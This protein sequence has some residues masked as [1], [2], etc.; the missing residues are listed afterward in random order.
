MA[1]SATSSGLIKSGGIAKLNLTTKILPAALMFAVLA[2]LVIAVT[3]SGQPV[4]AQDP[5]PTPTPEAKGPEGKGKDIPDGSKEASESQG[6]GVV[7]YAC[8]ITPLGTV[9]GTATR[10][11]SWSSDCE[12]VNRSDRYARFYSFTVSETSDV[13][14]DL[15][16]SVDTYM[17]LLSGSGTSGS[18]LTY[19]DDG[20]VG[21]DSQIQIELSAGT[22][23]VEATTYSSS[24][25]GSFTL[26][27]EA[28]STSPPTPV[29]TVTSLGT[30]SGTVTRI[31]SW[32][33]D[34]ESVNRSDK[35]A[36]FYSFSVGETS[37][38]QIDLSASE[39]TYM[40]LLSGSGTTG[41]VLASDDDGGVGR[42]SQIQ[43]ELSAGTYTVEA[44][45]FSSRRTG[46]FTLTIQAASTSTP[47]TPT[48]TPTPSCTV[49]SLGTISSSVTRIGSWASDCESANRSGRYARFYSISVA[50]TSD[51]QIDLS[52]SVDTY[53]YL[54]SG[55]GTTGPVLHYDDD[56]GDD[57]N[58]RIEATLSA[59]TYT[60]EATTYASGLTGSFTLTIGVTSD[61]P[62]IEIQELVTTMQQGQSDSFRVW[63]SNLDPSYIY[64]A[65]ITTSN[66]DLAFTAACASTSRTETLPSSSISASIAFT[67]HG[68]NAPG[69]RVT[70]TL[71]RGS[72]FV[73]SDY[74]DVEVTAAPLPSLTSPTAQVELAGDSVSVAYNL[75]SPAQ[76]D[77]T[78]FDY[79]LRLKWGMNALDNT[80]NLTNSRTEDLTSALGV[81]R[82]TGLAPDIDG[83]YRVDVE[84]CRTGS[85]TDCISY[86]DVGFYISTARSNVG[87][88]GIT[89]VLAPTTD[90]RV[91]FQIDIAAD[92]GR[93]HLVKVDADTSPAGVLPKTYQP[94][95][96]TQIG[97]APAGLQNL[98]DGQ[99]VWVEAST[100][101]RGVTLDVQS[102]HST[103]QGYKVSISK[104]DFAFVGRQ[105]ERMPAAGATRGTI[106][107][108][109][110][111]RNSSQIGSADEN[112]P[113]MNR[114]DRVAVYCQ[115]P[116]LSGT[117]VR[118]HSFQL[119][120]QG[121]VNFLGPGSE[122][123]LNLGTL[124]E[125][126]ALNPSP[127]APGQSAD[128]IASVT[129][130]LFVDG[131]L[132]HEVSTTPSSTEW[133]FNVSDTMWHR[134]SDVMGGLQLY[135][136]APAKTS[137]CT[138]SFSVELK[139]NSAA[140]IRHH[141]S[142]NDI[143]AV[144]TTG[145][146]HSVGVSWMQGSNTT[147]GGEFEPLGSTLVES[148]TTTC[149]F[150]VDVDSDAIH[151]ELEN[152]NC[153][154]GDQTYSEVP[155]PLA[156]GFPNNVIF[157]PHTESPSTIDA[158]IKPRIEYFA[159][160]NT[161]VSPNPTVVRFQIVGARPPRLG[162]SVHKA[163]R[164][165]GWTSGSISRYGVNEDATCPGNPVG[166]TDNQADG[167]HLECL[168]FAEYTSRGG[169]SGSPVFVLADKHST[170]DVEV[171]LVGV[172]YGGNDV[173]GT[174][175]FV[176][177]DRVYAESLLKGYDWS[178]DTQV[179][180][181]VP[182]LDRPD[183]NEM[184]SVL[185]DGPTIRAA[186][187]MTDFSPG[188]GLKYQAG[189]FRSTVAGT[190]T[191]VRIG[192]DD[193]MQTVTR[194]DPIVEFDLSD[195]GV[196]QRSGEF[197]VKA[198]F[199]AYDLAAKPQTIHCGDY[200]TDGGKAVT[201]VPAPSV[202]TLSRLANGDVRVSW[203]AVATTNEYKLSYRLSSTD[204]PWL[205]LGGDV[206][207][208][209][210]ADVSNLQCGSNKS[211]EFRVRAHADTNDPS[212][213]YDGTWGFW[214]GA[215]SPILVQCTGARRSVEAKPYATEVTAV[216]GS[217]P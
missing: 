18:V 160:D 29:C 186:F 51:V 133:P 89:T 109:V 149:K 65:E 80:A 64:T 190:P 175:A 179:V 116:G 9:S 208:T 53:V 73:D 40:F 215:S 7:P 10:S 85:M 153:H 200:G 183:P 95:E 173:T 201:P 124:C 136:V 45:T 74:Q 20:G 28:S 38:V 6:S 16:S 97:T 13:Q 101:T 76:P 138:S 48:P 105:V 103:F 25:T 159:V 176:P 169:D 204:D 178:T 197:S 87:N 172:H 140:T 35:Y 196:D 78:E 154:R 8:T 139:P 17:F 188:L 171:I 19:D 113:S 148:P 120:R 127:P 12:S 121:R 90:R 212:N 91:E 39:D 47:P 134:Q 207:T 193:A 119:L 164:T 156:V 150:M 157:K 26:T 214:S 145:H 187:D 2:I 108:T 77:F 205:E 42:D 54:L 31:G 81:H 135:M 98:G 5:P 104:P 99:V 211:Y 52:S 71:R 46:S 112:D 128:Q 118:S 59:G 57:R 72:T 33:N 137:L 125:G 192:T 155:T 213:P 210:A 182:T 162:E 167:Y 67:L 209:T 21:R 203:N 37:D 62:S 58:S 199:C 27:I 92:N 1:A 177:I 84:V 32:A 102:S 41:S 181:P 22:Y 126:R 195:L 147:A 114:V 69:G 49:T 170:N 216:D 144:A 82:F 44:T 88:N 132:Q 79:R 43:I 142:S 122:Q 3:A 185:D 11:G 100:Q 34:C 202:P 14:I 66:G 111:I 163:G 23:M 217:S 106:S 166:A 30:I 83:W 86:G 165:T 56:G 68:C 143:Q 63:A 189:L 141:G 75:N 60:V 194:A 36:R 198:L 107:S 50:D 61:P 117:S 55:S 70:A 96:I 184:L 15:S 130:K 115:G 206:L 131:R 123:S 93:T 191:L 151:E 158:I 129:V 94:A 152:T 174:G 161:G 146:C 110:T 180:R 168:S 4:E 24:Q